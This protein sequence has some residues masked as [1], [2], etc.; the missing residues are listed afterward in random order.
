MKDNG[1]P[2]VESVALAMLDFLTLTQG[3]KK[4]ERNEILANFRDVIDNGAMP[5]TDTAN[6][7]KFWRSIGYASTV[8]MKRMAETLKM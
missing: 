6:K 4:R 2:S 3:M 8:Y 7:L 1:F 5:V